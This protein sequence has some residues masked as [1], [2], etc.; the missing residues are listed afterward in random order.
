MHLE[1]YN[2][3]LCQLATE[4]T[5]HHLF[6]ECPFARSCWGI[7]NLDIQPQ[8]SFPEVILYFRDQLNS[9]FF[10]NAVILMCWT[11]WGP[12]ND[13]IFRGIGPNIHSSKLSFN[14]ELALTAIRAKESIS[15]TYNQWIQN[16]P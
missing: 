16:W 1:T 4:E 15:Q 14:R 5:L 8:S 11:I 13:V 9:E 2:C 10:L 3:E 7:L 12:R 6:L